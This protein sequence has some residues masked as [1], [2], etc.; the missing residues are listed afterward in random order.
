MRGEIPEKLWKKECPFI[1]CF[2]H[3]RLLMMPQSWNLS[4]KIYLLTSQHRDGQL[5][6]KIASYFG[7]CFVTGSSRK[8]GAKALRQMVNHLSGG[9]CVG[10]TPDGPRGPRMR[11][12]EGIITI[13]Q[14]SGAPIV[15]ITFSINN[16]T[17]LNS[18]D[19]F[20]VGFPFGRG[21][22]IWGE[23]IYVDRHASKEVREQA[24]HGLENQLLKMTKDADNL[25]EREVIQPDSQELEKH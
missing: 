2:W 6:K 5:I 3:G 19:R 1:L 11:V 23:P 17:A 14:L 9:N 15:P 16:G 25:F 20:L 4:K 8:G 12:Q 7:F 21:I 24:R 13:A 18:W 10:L 22:F